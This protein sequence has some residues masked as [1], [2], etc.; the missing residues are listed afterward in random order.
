MHA[1]M[2]T[3]IHSCIHP[4]FYSFIHS[5][6]HSHIH[7]IMHPSMHPSIHASIRAC[8]MH[9]SISFRQS[10]NVPSR[11]QCARCAAVAMN[12]EQLSSRTRSAQRSCVQPVSGRHTGHP[13]VYRGPSRDCQKQAA[14]SAASPMDPDHLLYQSMVTDRCPFSCPLRHPTLWP[15]S[16]RC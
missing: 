13:V 3:L 16:R 5:F 11:G 14:H 2:H 12:H 7:P 9:P 15:D 10:I 4:S 6:I 1:C 8:I